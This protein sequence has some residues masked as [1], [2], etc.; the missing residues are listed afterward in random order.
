MA[1][2]IFSM[3]LP[4]AA[5]AAEK[6]VIVVTIVNERNVQVKAQSPHLENCFPNLS[7]RIE[8]NGSYRFDC[9]VWDESK[10]TSFVVRLVLPDDKIGCEGFWNPSKVSVTYENNGA[11][12]AITTLGTDNYRLTIR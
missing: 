2:A 9:K 12:C 6:R 3:A 8:P 7:E 5:P 10:K 4:M 11:R 1:L